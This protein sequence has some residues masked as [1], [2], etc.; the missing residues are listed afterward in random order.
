MFF[1]K[2]SSGTADRIPAPS[3][4]SESPPVA[5][6]CIRFFRTVILSVIISW[7]GMF[8]KSATRP[9]PHASCSFSELYKPTFNI[10]YHHCFS[11]KAR[12]MPEIFS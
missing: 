6:R 12:I 4:V 8:F 1:L 11:I 3:P 9:T 5:P 10:I 2:N 7:L